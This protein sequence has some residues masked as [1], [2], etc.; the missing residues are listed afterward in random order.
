M[1]THDVLP[2]REVDTDGVTLRSH[3]FLSRTLRAGATVRDLIDKLDNPPAPPPELCE[4]EWDRIRY[5]DVPVDIESI[6][7]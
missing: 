7:V 2:T 4:T 1:L 3:Q 6:K 5:G